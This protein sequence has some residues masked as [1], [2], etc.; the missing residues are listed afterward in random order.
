MQDAAC[1]E[2]VTV[3]RQQLRV[4]DAKTVLQAAI[5]LASRFGPHRTK[6]PPTD[7]EPSINI[8]E[9]LQD[10]EWQRAIAATEEVPMT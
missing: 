4:P 6:A 3:L 2:A 5:A 1:D 8:E 7:R 9:C 10:E